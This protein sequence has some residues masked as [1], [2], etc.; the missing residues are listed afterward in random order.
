MN[1]QTESYQFSFV[2]CARQ[3]KLKWKEKNIPSFQWIYLQTLFWFWLNHFLE[4]FSLIHPN[5]CLHCW[6]FHDRLWHKINFLL[7]F[8]ASLIRLV[9]SW[10]ASLSLM[11][12]FINILKRIPKEWNEAEYNSLWRFRRNKNIFC[13]WR[14][15]RKILGTEKCCNINSWLHFFS[16]S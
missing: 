9:C 12:N 11:R 6:E 15:A 2:L 16:W 14:I 8:I 13:L 1:L 5:L 7:F 3:R 10:F 4:L